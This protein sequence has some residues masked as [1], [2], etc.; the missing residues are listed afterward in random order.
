M[1]IEMVSGEGD[2]E[3]SLIV[4]ASSW[5]SESAEMM[6][7]EGETL[8][9]S[10]WESES[11]RLVSVSVETEMGVKI[12]LESCVYLFMYALTTAYAIHI[13]ILAAMSPPL[14]KILIFIT[15]EVHQLAM[16]RRICISINLEF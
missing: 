7:G 12:L 1:T 14:N 9:D 3:M 13:V 4:V 11:V 15:P 16:T 5:G 8:L 6:S 10:S 2:V